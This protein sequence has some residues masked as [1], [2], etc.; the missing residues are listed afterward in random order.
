MNYKRL[1]MKIT[2]HYA[3]E[4]RVSEETSQILSAERA[5]ISAAFGT[6]AYQLS[7]LAGQRLDRLLAIRELKLADKLDAS[8]QGIY[9]AVPK[10]CTIVRSGREW[11]LT[12]P[13]TGRVGIYTEDCK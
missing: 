2:A 8:W 12:S 7:R 1:I 5:G 10:G 9:R 11:I 6:T 3:L 13:K 4:S